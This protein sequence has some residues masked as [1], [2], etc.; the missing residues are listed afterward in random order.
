MTSRHAGVGQPELSVLPPTHD[1]GAFA[2]LV[3]PAAA[4]VQLQGDDSRGG[5]VA[6]LSVT[7]VAAARRL[8]VVGRLAVVVV[9]A[10]GLGVSRAGR[11]IPPAGDGFGV[12]GVVTLAVVLPTVV[13]LAVSLATLLVAVVVAGALVGVSRS[14]LFGGALGR[15]SAL[16]LAS[17]PT[18]VVAIPAVAWLATAGLTSGRRSIAT[19]LAVALVVA[20]A[21]VAAWRRRAL[22]VRRWVAT[23][24]LV[25][26]AA[27][28]V[29]VPPLILVAALIGVSAAL[30][31]VSALVG[32]S[33]A[34]VLVS[35]LVGV[36]ALIGVSALIRLARRWVSALG[37]IAALLR[38]ISTSGVGS[39]LLLGTSWIV[40]GMRVTVVVVV[41]AGPPLPLTA[42]VTRIVSH[43]W[44]SWFCAK[45]LI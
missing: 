37:R 11:G 23:L 42:A 12:L 17:R 1:V 5:P 13:L 43:W 20:L 25:G 3:G 10:G 6:A 33:A 22:L 19:T 35:A 21:A 28:L 34:L 24:A 44:Y 14:W 40:L 30:V 39:A 15:I 45:R 29:V 38:R 32:V 16:V 41:V 7:A 36:A 27:P 18:T 9:A 26:V 4:V 8:A 31:L 2:Q